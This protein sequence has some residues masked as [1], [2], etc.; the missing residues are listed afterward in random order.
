MVDKHWK[1]VKCCKNVNKKRNNENL[2][3]IRMFVLLLM[4]LRVINI[5]IHKV[6]FWKKKEKEKFGK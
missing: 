4:P 3:P 5:H 2:P 1:L 6:Q